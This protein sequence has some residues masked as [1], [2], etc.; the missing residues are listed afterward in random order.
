MSGAYAAPEHLDETTTRTDV[1]SLGVLS[2]ELLLERL[3]FEITGDTPAAQRRSVLEG[4]HPRLHQWAEA[5][6]APHLRSTSRLRWTELQ[7]IYDKATAFHSSDRYGAVQELAAEVQR[8]LQDRAVAACGAGHRSL[9]ALYTGWRF[10][11]HN[12]IYAVMLMMGTLA[13]L[14]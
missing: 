3:P 1:Y 12:A 11:G 2:A 7:A 9:H 8:L 4:P 14:A 5:S 13:R 10:L 6:T